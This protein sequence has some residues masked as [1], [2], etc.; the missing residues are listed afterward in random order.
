MTLTQGHDTPF[1]HRQQLRVIL[2]RSKMG[3]RSYAPETDICYE[4]TVTLDI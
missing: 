4:T 1:S 3:V 2:S